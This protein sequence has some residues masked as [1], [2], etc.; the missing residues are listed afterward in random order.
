MGH[1]GMC[2]EFC[3]VHTRSGCRYTSRDSQSEFTACVSPRAARRGFTMVGSLLTVAST[4]RYHCKSPLAGGVKQPSL[5]SPSLRVMAWRV[6]TDCLLAS[7]IWCLA[8]P[9]P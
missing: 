5:Y 2:T 8:R 4:A 6:F 1:V 9:T 7:G 3:V